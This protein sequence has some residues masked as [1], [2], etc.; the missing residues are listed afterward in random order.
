MKGRSIKNFLV[1]L[2]AYLLALFG[3]LL[4]VPNYFQYVW[5][6]VKDYTWRTIKWLLRKLTHLCELQRIIYGELPGA[7]RFLLVGKESGGFL[8]W[9]LIC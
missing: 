1:G 7:K 2:S 6:T 8:C 5:K 9:F 3:I 4:V